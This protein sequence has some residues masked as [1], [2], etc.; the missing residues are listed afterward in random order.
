L[1]AFASERPVVVPDIWEFWVDVGGTFTDAIGRHPDGR[2]QRYKMLSSGIIKGQIAEYDGGVNVRDERRVGDPDDIWEGYTLRCS[3]PGQARVET[4]KVLA[5]DGRT[6]AFQ[7]DAPLSAGQWLGRLCELS[8]EQPAPLVSVRYL[9]GLPLEQPL[10]PLRMRLG[11][12]RGTNALVTRTGADVVLVT[13]RGFA[14]VLRIGNQDRPQLF[15]LAVRKP[16]PLF[17]DVVEIDERVSS[18][19]DVLR[20]ADPCQIEQVLGRLRNRAGRS[21]AICLLNAYANPVHERIVADVAERLGFREISVSSEVASMMKIVAR[22]DTT[23][24]DAYLNPVLRSYVRGIG[25]NLR[26]GSREIRMMTSSGGLVAA[27]S[28]RGKDSILSGPAGGVVGVA[29]VAAAARL[30]RVIG[31][32]MG[33]TSTDVSR[34]EGRFDLQ[35]ENQKAGVRI[36]TPMMAIETVAAGGGSICGFDGVKLTVGPRSAGADPGPA[37]YGRGGPLAVTDVNFFLGRIR[38]EAFPFA[39]DAAAVEQRLDAACRQIR[40]Q[41]GH[42]YSPLELA[43]GFLRVAN[44]NMVEAIRSISVA[45]G[46]DPRD[47]VLIPFGGAAPQHACAVASELG[48]REILNHPDAGILSA[49]GIGMADVVRHRAAGVYR[50]WTASAADQ[51][52]GIFGRLAADV[53]RELTAEGFA[54]DQISVRRLLDLRFVGQD[55]FLT[56][57]EPANG[58]FRS[59]FAQEYERLYG[60]LPA[61]RDVEIVAARVEGAA[62]NRL[63]KSISEPAEPRA[64]QPIGQADVIFQ[65]QLRPTP[66][67]ARHA[68]QPG[69]HLE[70]PAIVTES[71]STTVIDPGWNGQVLTGGELLLR[72]AAEETVTSGRNAPR[73]QRTEV[74]TTRADPVTLEIFNRRFAAIAQQMGS[75]LQRT[76]SSVNVK[77]RLDFSCAVFTATGDLVVNA[78]HIPV[79]LGAMSET[80]RAVVSHVELSPHDVV[81]TND[82]YRGGSHLPDVTVVTP[83]HDPDTGEL[84]FFTASRAHHAE[85]GGVT[86]GSM[87]A[88]SKSLAEEGVLIRPFKVI[89]AGHSHMEEL[90]RLLV[91]AEYPTRNP[92][93]NLADI[94][95]QMAANAQGVQD[96]FRFVRQYSWPMVQ[97]YMQ[98]IQNAAA[99]KMRMA[100]ARLPDGEYSFTDHLDD[101]T[102]LA[103]RIRIRGEA[104]RLDFAGSGGVVPGNLNAN[105]AIV[106]AAVMYCLRCLIDE[107]IPLNEGV[108]QPVQL[109]VPAGLLNPPS[110]PDPRQCPAV[111]GGNVETSQRI[112]D[113]IL[114]ALGVAAASQG[115]MNNVLFGDPTFGYYETICGGSG[116]TAA[117]P[118]ADA[119]HTHMTNTRLTDPEVLEK[120]FPVRV[121]EF[122]IRRGSGGA[123]RHRGGAGVIRQLEFLKPVELSIVS[124]RRGPYPPYGLQGGGPGQLGQNTIVRRDGR[125]EP[126][127]G[128]ARAKV[129]PGDVLVVETPGGGGY[130][131]VDA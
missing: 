116:A 18:G 70:G 80:V 72:R 88:F 56:I 60:Y 78:P 21:L 20:S 51:L 90:R 114:G 89:Q 108:L 109:R 123:G 19:G 100:L 52:P 42:E 131:A 112:V 67:F 9:L 84:L 6:G 111:A 98:H 50:A 74:H 29:R 16:A 15:Q 46:F 28:F 23:V 93:D 11:T 53:R 129:A 59:C 10:P 83:V 5:F 68:L 36:V 124:Q 106:L 43:D 94:S 103:V 119:V 125:R 8:S 35:Y 12:T 110:H 39:L 24:V 86:P 49:L 120:R 54:D 79:H 117:G 64:P 113:V 55:A 48:I 33:G 87:P 85:I 4:R 2:L 92:A 71:I 63:P 57:P 96:L 81:V 128:L 69:D 45:R 27:A 62:G 1:G 26:G 130:G 47:H 65:S 76:A 32:D 44:T 122:A 102:P 75:A 118:G 82:P 38:A 3:S 13:T 99:T 77:E 22:G 14:D 95:A 41:A 91:T 121:R 30:P 127:P 104:A 105:R 25:E 17:Q 115:T 40:Q 37:C 107:D 7:L 73:R 34:F 126:L 101:G 66:I 31:F 58:D 61:A 97:A